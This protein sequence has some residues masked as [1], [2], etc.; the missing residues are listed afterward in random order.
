MPDRLSSVHRTARLGGWLMIPEPLIVEAAAQAGFDW[1]GIDLQH[2]TWDVNLAFRGIQ[3]L[4]AYRIPVLVRV[5]ELE[6]PLIPRVLDHGASGV[7]IAMASSPEL[8]AHAVSMA[9]YAPEGSRSYGGQR[10]GLRAEP[11]DVADVRPAVHP[12]LEDA[13]G[14]AAAREIAAVPGVAG[15]HIGPADLALGLGLG[16]GRDHPSAQA[17]F[18]AIRDAAHEH[19][20]PVAMHA[21]RGEQAADWIAR[22]FDEVVLTADIE[23]VRGALQ[24]LVATARGEAPPTPTGPYGAPR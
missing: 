18:D 23:V 8:V 17:A 21:V 20:L 14:V 9:R 19:G 11:E 5:S 10:Y 7:V 2:G 24:E 1:I 13:R 4:D 3:L 6:L 16:R 12:M 15:L 22:G